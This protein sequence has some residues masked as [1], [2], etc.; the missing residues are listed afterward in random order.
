MSRI[1]ENIPL[2][3][4]NFS[5]EFNDGLVKGM[6]GGEDELPLSTEFTGFAI[7]TNLPRTSVTNKN[8]AIALN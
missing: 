7:P 6:G 5:K 1:R 2:S 4:H 8:R 3:P